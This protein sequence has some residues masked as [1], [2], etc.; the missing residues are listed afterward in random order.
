M[1]GVKILDT[2]RTRTPGQAVQRRVA[3]AQRDDMLFVFGI[4]NVRKKFAEAP[5]AALVE[6]IA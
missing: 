4:G 1:L 5:N 6:R 3:F 2:G